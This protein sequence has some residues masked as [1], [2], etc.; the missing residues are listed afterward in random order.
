MKPGAPLPIVVLISGGGT[1]LQSIID[2]A[3]AG[4]L[5]VEIRAVISNRADAFGLER[6][7]RGGIHT[8]VLDHR[9]APDRETYDRLLAE[10]I[11][12]FEP[13]LV[14]LAGFMRILTPELVA[15][16]SG[17]MLNIHPSLLP[18]FRG[19]HTHRRALEAEV[20][21]HGASVH[22]VTP[23]LDS[24]PVIVQA[25]VPVLPGDDAEALAARVLAQEHRIYPLAIRWFAEGRLRLNGGRV[26]LDGKSLGPGGH[27]FRPEAA[28]AAAP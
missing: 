14:V 18:A 11:D 19:L 28:E 15:H 16:Y 17:R 13:G 20:R 12:R 24:G 25:R 22:F 8:E 6:A 7:R 5:P 4:A 2:A 3:A 10:L 9:E 26:W 27:E 21:E 23:E 1:N